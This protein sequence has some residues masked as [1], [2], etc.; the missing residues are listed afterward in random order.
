MRKCHWYVTN[1]H[2]LLKNAT[3]G[4]QAQ[5]GGASCRACY[6]HSYPLSACGARHDYGA[7]AKSVRTTSPVENVKVKTGIVLLAARVRYWPT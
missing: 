5:T 7:K 3:A 1:S 2:L 6:T 4:L